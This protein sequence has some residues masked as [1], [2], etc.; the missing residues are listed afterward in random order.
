M[1][2][3][4][5]FSSISKILLDQR[6]AESFTY[7][8][9]YFTLFE[10]AFSL[11][12][13]KIN[14]PGDSDISKII[15]GQRNVPRDIGCIYQYPEHYQ[16]LKNAV[17]RLL[18]EVFDP[19]FVVK[20]LCDLLMDDTTLSMEIRK[21]IATQKE[22][23]VQF[24]TSCIVT[25][26]SRSFTPRSKTGE[27]ANA[28][29]FE[30]SD[31]L[32]DCNYPAVN[33]VFLGR[34]AELDIIHE[35]L[36]SEHCLFLQGIGGIGK[37][38]LAKQYGKQFKK[39]YEHVLYLRYA[40]SLHETICKLDF[41]DDVPDMDEEDVFE[42]HYRFFKRLSVH[43]LVIID[44]FDAL[45]EQ[46]DLFQEFLS[47][48]FQVLVTSRNRVEE[49]PCYLVKEI[50]DIR[51]LE[52]L[53]YTYAPRSKSKPDIVRD[54]IKE[55]HYHTLTLE[56]VA[57][58]MSAADLTPE[59]VLAALRREGL[60]L[61]GSNKIR[62]QKDAMASK[63]TPIEHLTRLFQL[64]QLSNENQVLLR[65]L[66]LMP[67]SG[68]PKGLFVKWTGAEDFNG[69]NALIDYGWIHEEEDTYR[70]SLHPFLQEVLGIVGRPSFTKCSE[71]IERLGQ[72]Y[73]VDVAEEIHF[74][75]LLDITKGIFKSIE[76]DDTSLASQLLERVLIYLEKY[77]YYNTMGDVL[78]MMEAAVPRGA[79]H[80][81][82]AA[83][84]EFYRGVEAWGCGKWELAAMYFQNGIASIRPFEGDNV[85][86]AINLHDKLSLYY[87]LTNQQEKYLQHSKMVVELRERYELADSLEYEIGK[88][89][90]MLAN[91][92]NEGEA[93][94]LDLAS[95]LENPQMKS[96]I[97]KVKETGNLSIRKEEFQSDLDK[98]EPEELPDNISVIFRGVK[99]G[100]QNIMSERQDEISFV[101]IWE[102]AIEVVK[103][104]VMNE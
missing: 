79:G 38:E 75:D 88:V 90:L 98:V 94:S 26:L 66:C 102:G 12:D 82:E 4:F 58:T 104:Q 73:V 41:V 16:E 81:K 44:N 7:V 5:N 45:P 30:L 55:V 85:I 80:E 37:S 64:Q 46:E 96:F 3:R 13:I 43:T 63:A 54:I 77:M 9:Y 10:Y 71:F 57:R 101:D 91:A 17:A 1:R 70:I 51:A 68:I 18:E 87:L 31:F 40:G 65:N 23:T 67:A 20:Q 42:I 25:S 2:E 39:E 49:V 74:R 59:E 60:H 19:Y 97:G 33:K 103:K 29:N 61:S 47:L 32:Y 11:E 84:Y 76:M 8:E 15:N 99:E 34:E 6:K 22:D 89:N 36:Q 14:V 27:R 53:F 62:I 95:L 78:N 35:R 83:T 86:L 24:V 28:K 92:M 93:E 72:E 48:S 100:L 21:S 69:I 56:M 50:G 52:E